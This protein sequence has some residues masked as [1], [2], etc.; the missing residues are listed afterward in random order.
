MAVCIKSTW[1]CESSKG[2]DSWSV[3]S[4]IDDEVYDFL[5]ISG[6]TCRWYRGCHGDYLL[7]ET[8]Y[9]VDTKILDAFWCRF[10][11]QKLD[12]YC[13][14]ASKSIRSL[15]I[16][17][18]DLLSV[19]MENGQVHYVSL[20]FPVSGVWPIQNGLLIERDTLGMADDNL[21]LLF[22]LTHPLDDV[23][24]VTC[25]RKDL[26]LPSGTTLDYMTS[27]SLHVT[28]VCNG[29]SHGTLVLTYNASDKCRSL[30]LLKEATIDDVPSPVSTPGRHRHM[31]TSLATPTPLS[32][33]APARYSNPFV[34][35]PLKFSLQIQ[36][37]PSSGENVKSV[38]YPS[39][40]ESVI[41]SALRRSIVQHPSPY[42]ASSQASSV[43]KS[44]TCNDSTGGNI[45]GRSPFINRYLATQDRHKSKLMTDQRAKSLSPQLRY[46]RMSPYSQTMNSRSWSTLFNDDPM[47][48]EQNKSLYPHVCFYQIWSEVSSLADVDDISS[49]SSDLFVTRDFVGRD[50]VCLYIPILKQLKLLQINKSGLIIDDVCSVISNIKK[51][52]HLDSLNFI[53]TLS[54]S[55][56]ISLYSGNTKVIDVDNVIGYNDLIC[57]IK[58]PIGTDFTIVSGDGTFYWSSVQKLPE[59]SLISYCINGLCSVL[60]ND[61]ATDLMVSYYN[62]MWSSCDGSCYAF[63][64]WLTICLG[65]A[66]SCN[67]ISVKKPCHHL[68]R[69]DPVLKILLAKDNPIFFEEMSVQISNVIPLHHHIVRAASALHLI[70]Q[71]IKLDVHSHDQISELTELLF[72]LANHLGWSN[73][74]TLYC[75]DN[76]SLSQ[77]TLQDS[78]P[79]DDI[80]MMEDVSLFPLDAVPD[81][82]SFIQ[83]LFQQSKV[84]KYP[85]LKQVCKRTEFVIKI[86]TILMK[87]ISVPPCGLIN[88]TGLT[89][90]P[91]STM[92]HDVDTEVSSIE[93]LLAYLEAKNVT[94]EKLNTYPTGIIQPVMSLLSHC[95]IHPSSTWSPF[96]YR[97][98]GRE[99]ILETLQG[100]NRNLK[101]EQPPVSDDGMNFDDEILRLCFPADLRLKEVK[102]L[103]C[104][105]NPIKICLEQKPEVN[106]HQYTEQLEAKL[107]TLC[108]RTMALPVGRGIFGLGCTHPIPTE[109]FNIP[110][111]NIDGEVPPKKTSVSL[112]HVD[113]PVNMTDW[114]EFHNGV[115]T[116]LKISPNI[117]KLESTWVVFN[118]PSEDES[119]C[120]YAGF[121]MGLGLNG[122]LTNLSSFNLF[123]YLKEKHEL[124]V[125]GLLLGV[126]V[127]RRGTMDLST[128]SL[129]SVFFPP[130]LPQGAADLEITTLMQTAAM[131]SLGLLYMKSCNRYM[132]QIMLKEIGRSP[133]PELEFHHDRESYSLSAGLALGM[134]G[135][136]SGADALKGLN[137]VDNLCI[138]IN[139]GLKKD[140]LMNDTQQPASY[141]IL[142]TG[143]VNTHVTAS[144][145][146]LALGMLYLKSNNSQVASHLYPPSSQY[147]LESIR[148]DAFILR[149]LS[150]SLIL[151]D[152]IRPDNRWIDSYVPQVV[153][154][155]SFI[156][157]G[158]HI[159]SD[160]V[161]VQTMNQVLLYITTGCCM[162]LGFRFAGSCNKE[163]YDI[164]MSKY[165][166]FGSLLEST[167]GFLKTGE[168]CIETCLQN[169]LVSLALVMSGSG[170]LNILRLIRKHHSKA[171]LTY[172][173]QMAVH[174]ALGFLFLGG[175]RY[176]LNNS[177]E[178]IVGLICA[179]YPLYPQTSTD[180][181]Y[182][183]QALRHF[184]VL[185]TE[186]H[187]L[188]TRDSLTGLA[189]SV[190]INIYTKSN[191][192]ICKRTP[193]VLP[194]WDHMSEI[195]ILGPRYWSAK[196]NITGPSVR[197]P[198][199][200]TST[201]YLKQHVGYS[202]YEV[203][204]KGYK[205]SLSMAALSSNQ[206]LFGNIT[207]KLDAADIDTLLNDPNV[208]MFYHHFCTGSD[209]KELCTVLLD[210]VNQEK[211]EL[212]KVYLEL[213]QAAEG[214][215][216]DNIYSI[217]EMWQLELCY[218]LSHSAV[219]RLLPNISIKLLDDFVDQLIIKAKVI[220][221]S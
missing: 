85:L 29:G 99:D 69:C 37:S 137:V 53:V 63:K 183:L 142:E 203:D 15:C 105:S 40:R 117:T 122:H 44:L 82:F 54:L 96:I 155:Y 16:R 112:D 89:T 10:T 141:V 131:I 191:A 115:A 188:L 55:G 135:L 65:L 170:N 57:D 121:L 125:I 219:P 205:S 167:S 207:G 43:A 143:C 152:N 184:F 52:I 212:L 51:A 214:I 8:T 93:E 98:I 78:P 106:D 94:L 2:A 153:K 68:L 13:S 189:C 108:Q 168:Y 83:S 146:I 119:V 156:S 175:G 81:I 126:S 127:S 58:Y 173:H 193:C 49:H 133:G 138:Y 221:K 181:K 77:D 46:D 154:E 97:L 198:L 73:F 47:L 60:P 18:N 118:H 161:D 59:N 76:P 113:K 124:T 199:K 120:C 157:E 61:T 84:Q 174:M 24:P 20:P 101:M 87:G 6:C 70:Y 196:Y 22:T 163:V 139:G 3:S 147:Q 90:S 218:A 48:L 5:Q 34:T 178:G 39:L 179:L 38:K 165:H 187:V 7:L 166:L 215:Y 140:L 176:C 110:Y 201:I 35:T 62:F 21:S 134:I 158:K 209:N 210:C 204:P 206:T 23:C 111:L 132:A 32:S 25:R 91:D 159:E 74:M 109:C 169:I 12:P 42:N 190:P 75:N 71:E 95:K 216:T 80:S 11:D 26:S 66:K 14:N 107:L 27:P 180:N 41:S 217:I 9:S 171:S 186:Q 195:E 128:A 100:S 1:P 36:P 33:S 67:I 102:N 17:E 72:E 4:S 136:C 160:D 104:S 19:F 220:R 79:L 149:T 31:E 116:G 194:N 182:H 192:V 177:N 30:W 164:I 50:F 162:A 86:Y 197:Q 88:E 208:A 45:S 150:C 130:L 172:G 64:S 202:S 151:W 123:E 213:N 148:P 103:L 185:A 144:G 200:D 114:P 211:L 145:A 28:S 129:L 56:C 92:D